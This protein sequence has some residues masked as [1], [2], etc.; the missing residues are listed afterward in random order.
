MTK[1][2][3]SSTTFKILFICLTLFL[4]NCAGSKTTQSPELPLQTKWVLE[5]LDGKGV[6]DFAQSWL[7]FSEDGKISGS[8][9]CNRFSGSY[10][11]NDQKVET[12][13]LAST[14][15]ACGEALDHQEFKFFEALGQPLSIKT[16]NGLL[17]MEGNGRTL[18]F[19]RME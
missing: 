10:T 17:F 18:R 9:G 7:M 19:S 2:D 4:A 15:M 5:D 12:G 1:K 8:G 6:I 11:F 13:P 16:E 3:I 14:R